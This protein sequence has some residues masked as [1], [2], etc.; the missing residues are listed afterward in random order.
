M[1]GLGAGLAIVRALVDVSSNE[2]LELLLNCEGGGDWGFV[3][4]E[5]SAESEEC[6]D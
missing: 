5:S 1:V 2:E 4:K 3:F 6:E